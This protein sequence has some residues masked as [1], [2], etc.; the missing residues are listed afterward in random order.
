MIGVV[1]D[2]FVF[3]LFNESLKPGGYSLKTSPCFLD[4]A[5]VAS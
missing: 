3:V 5:F 4:R 1:Q 2:G